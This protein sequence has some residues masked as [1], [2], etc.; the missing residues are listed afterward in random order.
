MKTALTSLILF[1]SVVSPV[2]GE[3]K[4]KQWSDKSRTDIS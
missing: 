2:F 3:D 1:T 4:H